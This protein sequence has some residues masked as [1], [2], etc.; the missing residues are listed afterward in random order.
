M[1]LILKQANN[2]FIRFPLL[3]STTRE[4]LRVE[5]VAPPHLEALHEV[6]WA[7]NQFFCCFF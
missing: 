5:A 6:A 7:S 2:V 3:R 1:Y 4:A